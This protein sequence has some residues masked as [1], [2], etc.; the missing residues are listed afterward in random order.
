MILVSVIIPVYN[1][2]STIVAAVESALAQTYQNLEIVVVDDGSTD[3]TVDVLKP[4]SDRIRLICQKNA[5]PS[6]ARNRGVKESTGGIVAF[7]DSDDHW[8]PEKIARQTDLMERAGPGM[9]CCVCNATVKG[10]MGQVI[11]YTF[12][13]AGIR[14]AFDEGVWSNPQ[15]LLATRF[16]LFN[17]VV[18]VRRE[19]FE[20]AGGYAE[21]MRLLEDYEL[22]LRLTSAGRWGVI[23]DP[24]V[25]K[26]NDTNGIGVE[27]MTDREKHAEVQAS[28]FEAILKTGIVSESKSQKN[29]RKQLADAK[30]DLRIQHMMKKG[31]VL[32]AATG[33]V[34]ASIL[35]IRKAL[36]RRMPA[37][38]EFEGKAL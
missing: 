31:M 14:P 21:H 37:W 36:R 15:E 1:R 34:L 7:L 4:Y 11:G 18:A 30:L 29:M 2:D 24:L 32:S 27:C 16:L 35:R 25:I 26:H 23:R 5:G 38:P 13:F 22:S 19:A 33:A 12:D 9:C 3:A 17:Q 8:H 6:A 10:A 20:K 28:V